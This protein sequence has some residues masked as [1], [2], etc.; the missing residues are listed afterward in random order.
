MVSM[1]IQIRLFLAILLFLLVGCVQQ[2]QTKETVK[3]GAL[4][5]LTGNLAK[6]GADVKAA[7]GIAQEDFEAEF[8]NVE[9]VFEDDGFQPERSVTGFQKLVTADNVAAVI[10]PLNGSA[11]EAVRPL[12]NQF[13]TISFTPWGAG[14]RMDNF[15][16][17]TS[18]EA[19]AEAMAVA[20][21]VVSKLGI[22]Q[23]G[24]LFLQNDWGQVH[25]TAFKKRVE[26]LG[27]AVVVA[28]PY[29]FGTTDF[30]TQLTKMKEANIEGLYILENGAGVGRVT[31][32]AYQLGLQVPF[33]GQYATESSDLIDV[34]GESLEGLV[35]SFP[36]DENHLTA[37]QLEFIRKFE[38]KTGG[39]PQVAAYNAY[40]AYA[41]LLVAIKA[42][43]TTDK[44]CLSDYILDLK[45]FERVSGTFSY[46]NDRIERPFY[47]KTIQN[48]KFVPYV[49]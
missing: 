28:E 42:C 41:I 45:N 32:Q 24:V 15:V 20:D 40:D 6:V 43:G 48:G 49:R 37:K 9:I 10:G 35:Y 44:T 31:K 18:V 11:I 4:L 23:S 12:A 38:A 2:T 33:F 5:P 46:A 27:G 39:K 34:G 36:I 1:R 30:R 21:L 26:E 8:P 29:V 47:F 7:L 16:I 13:Q 14:N 3:I 22:K 17:K 25:N 19:D